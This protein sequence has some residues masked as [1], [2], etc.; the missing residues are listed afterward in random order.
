MEEEKMERM[1]TS[2][3]I[4]CFGIGFPLA[5]AVGEVGPFGYALFTP[6]IIFLA[7]GM[8]MERSQP[9]YGFGDFL[10]SANRVVLMVSTV[11]YAGLMTHY[12]RNSM[13]F[14]N[15]EVI[16]REV[17]GIVFGQYFEI[18]MLLAMLVI[19]TSGLGRVLRYE[20]RRKPVNMFAAI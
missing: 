16:R 5:H 8:A 3:V 9:D 17:P 4:L 11:V 7:I 14:T 13:L 1:I 6:G 19:V 18:V 12:M 15:G 2:L 10:C 20:L